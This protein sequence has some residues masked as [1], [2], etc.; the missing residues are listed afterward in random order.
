MA[1][2]TF[3]SGQEEGL[4]QFTEFFLAPN[5]SVMLLKG[6]SGTGKS[7]LVKE[8][9]RRLP[10]LEAM[11][12]LISSDFVPYEAVLS[13]TTNQAAES[14]SI[15]TGHA[16]ETKT[17]HSVLGLR[18]QI[19]DYRTGKKVL[20]PTLRDKVRRKLIFID[21]VSYIDRMLLQHIFNE[22][23]DC[24]FVFIGD[25]AQLTPVG[26][27][28]MP[29]F[30]MQE[31]QI[32]L[33]QP[34]RF[35]TGP[36]A[37]LVHALRAT[38]V[39]GAKYPNF[40]NFVE[41][42]VLEKLPMAVW[43]QR[44]LEAFENPDVWGS[45]KILCYT[46]DAVDFYNKWLTEHFHGDTTPK[47]GQ[48]LVC[49]ESKGNGVS[50]LNNNCEVLVTEVEDA[51]VYGVPGWRLQLRSSV[52][53]YFMPA[54]RERVKHALARAREED[55]FT[56]MREI[57]ENWVDLRPSFAC[58]VNKSQGSTYDYAFIDLGNIVNK[59]KQNSQLARILY[60]GCSRVRKGMF[61]QG[62]VKG[63]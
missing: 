33:T 35:E 31:R 47:P 19:D 27:N 29:V 3:T 5:E 52:G 17:I 38:V 7:T 22:T 40:S 49:N 56:A 28:F 32:E 26:S 18:L 61:F 34:T 42:G 23:E 12:K 30:Q 62:D 39:E 53:S 36:V 11:A 37:G 21:E 44:V 20:V 24:K 16:L 6:Y 48:R 57:Q 46:N 25:P 45:V 51:E 41:P 63:A 15:A 8:I 59:V 1:E 13:A 60:V 10:E 54:S 55:D 4:Q 58:T 9:I 14:L 43:Q 2:I 50:R